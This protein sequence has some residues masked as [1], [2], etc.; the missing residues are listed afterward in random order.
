[1]A[2]TFVFHIQLCTD[3]GSCAAN[4]FK[5]KSSKVAVVDE[6]S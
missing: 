5:F 3:Y 6:I 1:V 4:N 2:I